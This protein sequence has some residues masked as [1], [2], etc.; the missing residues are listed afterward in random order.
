M[1]EW[2]HQLSSKNDAQARI[3]F[4]GLHDFFRQLS[5]IRLVAALADG[6]FQLLQSRTPVCPQVGPH[7]LH[8]RF[9]LLGPIE[10]DFVRLRRT[11]VR[12][13]VDFAGAA[14][15]PDTD[16]LSSTLMAC[17]QWWL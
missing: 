17:L 15:V 4:C 7:R 14:S 13:V 2:V 6:V 11:T 8:D 3:D 12:P 9:D 10:A 1:F 16:C 5:S